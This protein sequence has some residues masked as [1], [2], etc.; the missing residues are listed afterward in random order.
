MGWTSGYSSRATIV[1]ERLQ[2]QDYVSGA[3]GFV[4]AH[5]LRGNVLWTVNEM[6]LPGS[7]VDG[8]RW[9]GCTLIE[10]WGA[11]NWAVKD[12]D[13]TCGPFYYTC[14]LSY[15]DMVAPANWDWR[16]GVRNYHAQRRAA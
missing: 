16:E 3:K 11:G 7:P 6:R 4:V 15:L 1:N 9:I 10:R 14:P 5:C 12:L 8:K 2:T 13:E